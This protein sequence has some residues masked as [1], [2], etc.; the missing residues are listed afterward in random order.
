[1]KTNRMLVTGV[2]L[3]FTA[4][5]WLYFSGMAP[6]YNSDDSP[7]TSAAYYTLGI[8]HPPGYPLATLIG[9]IFMN[10]QLG[11]PAFR[12]NLMAVFFSVF[13]GF[14]IFMLVYFCITSRDKKTGNF[15][16][17]AVSA[18]AASFYLFSGSA[19]LQGS[20]G[21]GGLYALNSFLLAS[22]LY[23]L[24]R[25]NEG[26]KYLYLFAVIYGISMGNH[27]TSMIVISPAVLYYL[28]MERKNLTLKRLLTA[29]AFFILGA[30]V[31]I[32]V[33]LRNLT[34]PAY[35]WGDVKSIKDFIWLISRAQ[36]SGIE[37][38]HSLVDTLNLLGYYVKNLFQSEF[39]WG[40]AI[41]ILPGMVMLA[42]KQ[43]KKGIMLIA[44]YL[45]IMVSVASFATP[46]PKTEWLI[47]PYLVSTNIF[48][49]V[50]SA[51][52]IYY[53]AAMFKN[54]MVKRTLA[55]FLAAVV[56]VI[57]I[58]AN[59]PGYGRYFIGY[60][61]GN[62]MVKS[63]KPGSIIFL[64][65]DMNVGAM[66]YKSLV[67]KQR[68]VPVIPVVSLYGWYQE[69]VTRNFGSLINMPPPLKDLK[70]YMGSIMAA[71][72]GRDFYYSNIFTKQFVDEGAL[73][74]EG[75]V[76]KIMRNNMRS[77]ISDYL[78]NIYSYRG[79]VEDKVKSDEFT[80][81]LVIENYAMSFFN[82][83]DVLRNTGNNKIAAKYY[84]RG[85]IFYKNHGA[86][87]NAGLAC[88]YAG[89]LDKAEAMWQEALNTD[90]KDS[91]SYSN[92]A[93]I[94]LNKKDI[95]KAKEFIQKALQLDPNNQTALYLQKNIK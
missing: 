70:Q 91:V 11:S 74:P 22:C 89:E 75:I 71:N 50:F 35:C 51:F 78:F 30:S 37:V 60:E 40:T 56:T 90:P 23:A 84:E 24:F 83:A 4:C 68:F 2:M 76:I 81:R 93:F 79:M 15:T 17:A 43:A 58:A 53:I 67:E 7:E 14:M 36:Y 62:N 1:M 80:H 61:Y 41:L 94:Y 16:S 29:A 46:P 26:K 18:A 19:W 21:K 87:I 65:G 66:I 31:Y 39:P 73:K 27:W 5:F 10:V 88:Y 32:Y 77:V 92:M 38:K 63:I 72:P 59:R 34:G 42:L 25:M 12:A 6:S 95:P 54:T 20:I 33:P 52:S 8:Q 82:L 44:A 64:E 28:F 45:F 47:K 55:L 49:A 86:Y 85:L 69:Q 13:A 57:L 9:K 48:A 3:F